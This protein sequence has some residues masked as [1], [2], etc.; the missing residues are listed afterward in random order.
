MFVYKSIPQYLSFQNMPSF[1]KNFDLRHGLLR[2][3]EIGVLTLL[4]GLLYQLLQ[5]PN[6]K[7]IKN[8][9]FSTEGRKQQE[10]VIIRDTNIHN[11]HIP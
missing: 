1:V 2:I 11:S 4:I 9:V 3:T 8:S 5:F 7:K 10:V 6:H